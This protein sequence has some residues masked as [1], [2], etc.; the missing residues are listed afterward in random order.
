MLQAVINAVRNKQSIQMKYERIIKLC[1]S[2]P[3]LQRLLPGFV[4][5]HSDLC[6]NM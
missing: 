3:V 5:D 6:L 4:T 1:I 2:Q